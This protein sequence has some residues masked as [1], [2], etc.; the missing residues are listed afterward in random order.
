MLSSKTSTL[1]SSS[2]MTTFKRTSS[3]DEK[4]FTSRIQCKIKNKFF[5]LDKMKTEYNKLNQY[6]E[7]F[8]V[9]KLKTEQEF[10]HIYYENHNQDNTLASFITDH[11]QSLSSKIS[12]IL[13]IA[14]AL[15]LCHKNGIF[16]GELRPNRILISSG[17][18]PRLAPTPPEQYATCKIYTS[19]S[20]VP[21][22]IRYWP[23]DG[24]IKEDFSF[25]RM[26]YL[27]P[28]LLGLSQAVATT[29][30]QK[31]AAPHP[32]EKSD[33]YTL[34]RL[35]YYV[36]YEI[37]PWSF[38]EN[39]I[40]K[41]KHALVTGEQPAALG[42]Y[43]VAKPNT[44]A[45]FFVSAVETYSRA[46]MSENEIKELEDFS[47]QHDS[48]DKLMLYCCKFKA[49]ERPTLSEVISHL[50]KINQKHEKKASTLHNPVPVENSPAKAPPEPRRCYCIIS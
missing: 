44:A 3:S 35:M 47:K 40:E 41:L 28:E 43:N 18:N 31:T 49:N 34:G 42:S 37:D 5:N 1:S 39:A 25:H 7:R 20:L 10:S 38:E 17:I 29:I 50:E 4:I 8:I 15:D 26:Y 16:Y 30:N 27:A 33:V 9:A 2:N 12:I 14:K 11:T 46:S 36:L 19:G 21:T 6:P 24:K 13:N 22:N 45:S 48:L 23:E 32:T